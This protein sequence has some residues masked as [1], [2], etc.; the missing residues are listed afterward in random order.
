LNCLEL[1]VQPQ[2]KLRPIIEQ[3][4]M[5]L[6]N[7]ESVCESRLRKVSDVSRF[8]ERDCCIGHGSLSK[9]IVWSLGRKAQLAPAR[10]EIL[11]VSD[12]DSNR[13]VATFAHDRGLGAFRFPLLRFE[14]AGS[15]V[16]W[17]VVGHT[18]RRGHL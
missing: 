15:S 13:I 12:V 3:V 6:A 8:A 11:A 10:T 14:H 5:I 17:A 4:A 7:G 18:C 16:T 9:I 1:L 2:I